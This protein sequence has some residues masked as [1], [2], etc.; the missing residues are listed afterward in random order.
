MWAH[1]AGVAV[2][3][4]RAVGAAAADGRV[5]DLA[6]TADIVAVVVEQGLHLVFK[7]PGVHLRESV[8]R[9]KLEYGIV[10]DREWACRLGEGCPPA[11]LQ[12]CAPRC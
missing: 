8:A 1:R 3:Q 2:V 4:H 5:G 9:I 7:H 10:A 11:A 12:K 6:K